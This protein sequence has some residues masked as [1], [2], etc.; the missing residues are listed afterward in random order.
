MK[1]YLK[2]RNGRKIGIVHIVRLSLEF[3]INVLIAYV[4]FN[5]TGAIVKKVIMIC[6]AGM[7]VDTTLFQ[8]QLKL[9]NLEIVVVCDRS[10]IPPE[11]MTMCRSHVIEEIDKEP[12]RTLPKRRE[13][14]TI[15]EYR[16]AMRRKL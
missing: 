6:D 15:R 16:A 8:E 10:N 9:R 14:K 5:E 12:M 1:R 3:L 7:P 4:G 2:C 11:F 13:R